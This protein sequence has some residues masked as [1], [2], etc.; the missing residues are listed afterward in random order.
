[1]A[2]ETAAERQARLWKMLN[3]AES[4]E[5]IFTRLVKDTP[6][7]AVPPPPAPEKNVG[8]PGYPVTRNV[9]TQF[10]F[11]DKIPTIPDQNAPPPVRYVTP[12]T[13]GN[14]PSP[15]YARTQ[16]L[17]LG[18]V[19]PFRYYGASA[20]STM[21]VPDYLAT[22]NLNTSA[23]PRLTAIA[24]RVPGLDGGFFTAS[25][26]DALEGP[27][28]PVANF[29]LT[30][31]PVTTKDIDNPQVV[32]EGIALPLKEFRFESVDMSAAGLGTQN[33]LFKNPSLNIV[34]HE[35]PSVIM[36][37][38][39]KTSKITY[40][41][42][43]FLLQS[44][45]K[46]QQEKFQVIETFGKPHLYFYGERAR[47][48]NIQGILM[49]AFYDHLPEEDTVTVGN[50]RASNLSYRNQWALGFQNFYNNR[51]RGTKL[52]DAGA[53]AALYV[54]G[55]LVKGYPI[56]LSIMKES[57]TLPD[58]VTFQ[59]SWVIES[60][61]LLN[62]AKTESNYAASK[63]GGQLV[64]LM[65]EKSALLTRYQA[66]VT[67]LQETDYLMEAPGSTRTRAKD[68]QIIEGMSKLLT[69][70]EREIT[71]LMAKYGPKARRILNMD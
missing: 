46:P 50:S 51:L 14:M 37:L 38:D 63:D 39:K 57:N 2:K 10:S 60:E 55:W 29:T 61:L 26:S 49:D 68:V 34:S 66:L 23:V 56:S 31:V 5:A 52:K 11:G 36:I 62:S 58:A 3:N 35:T 25:S 28:V 69:E 44:I 71:L 4:S 67:K 17:N 6:K 64:A 32:P 43:K 70:K 53:I 45:T 59:M 41:T 21:P 27:S 20:N 30:A 19:S 65:N 7:T 33:L 48:Y 8:T 15:D 40:Q 12:E 13:T 1:M 16:N 54:N 22:R 47:V 18:V 42:N 9:P 24:P